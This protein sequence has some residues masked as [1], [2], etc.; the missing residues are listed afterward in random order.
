MSISIASPH[1]IKVPWSALAAYEKFA[2][3]KRTERL[4]VEGAERGLVT[5]CLQPAAG[6]T[7]LTGVEMLKATLAA[8]TDSP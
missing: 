8:L 6:L 3:L 7:D 4:I 2:M 1:M 5:Y